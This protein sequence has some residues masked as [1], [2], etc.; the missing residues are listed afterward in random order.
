MAD[1]KNEII[2]FINKMKKT[3]KERADDKE[4][5]NERYVSECYDFL[6]GNLSERISYKDIILFLLNGEKNIRFPSNDRDYYLMLFLGVEINPK[7]TLK[8]ACDISHPIAFETLKV[9]DIDQHTA[10]KIIE[11]IKLHSRDR[12]SYFQLFENVI[13]LEDFSMVG[14]V[15]LAEKIVGDS[16]YGAVIS[17]SSKMT[18]PACKFPRIYFD[19]GIRVPD[20]LIRSGNIAAD[21]DLHIDASKLKVFK[22]LTLPFE[23][24]TLFEQLKAGNFEPLQSIFGVDSQTAKAWYDQMQ[25][26]IT[27]QDCRTHDLIKQ[28]CFPVENDYHQLSLLQPSG[29][30]FKLKERIDQINSRSVDAYL[31]RR[32]YKE[33]KY[34]ANG[35]K[36]IPNLT[37]TKHGGEHPKN[38][39]GLNNKYQIYYLLDSRPPFIEKMDVKFPTRGFFS[40]SLRYYDCKEILERLDNVFKI[41]RNSQIPLDKIRKGRDRCLGDILDVILRKM[42]ALR[43]ASINQFWSETSNLPVWQKLWLCEQHQEQRLEQDDWLNMLCEQIALWISSA[44]KNSIKHPVILGEAERRYISDFIDDNKE[45]LR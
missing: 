2:K 34:Y 35:F 30:I 6:F 40:Q 19:S 39:S 21:F 45:V 43:E 28:V 12:L 13:D 29:L 24:G 33:D 25:V 38:I 23:K 11:N 27:S 7:V 1:E 22:F 16:K 15:D 8:D 44:Y 36:T 32:S 20:G 10:L 41:E 17:H 18:N 37:V 4:L 42:I 9:L 31:G 14:I 5:K 3:I 26:C